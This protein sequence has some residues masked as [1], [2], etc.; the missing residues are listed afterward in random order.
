MPETSV[1]PTWLV[2]AVAVATPLLAFA[3]VIVANVVT[4]MGDTELEVRSRREE[5]MRTLKWAAELAVSDDPAKADLGLRELRALGDSAMLD[6]EQQSFI[7]AALASVYG[8]AEAQIEA[9]EVEG[10]EVVVVVE[11]PVPGEERLSASGPVG[12][13][14]A[15]VSSDV[16]SETH[17]EEQHG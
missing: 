2:I 5:T 14:Q 17:G 4:R 6:P 16:D 12:P 1:V 15:P 10:E 13:G 11:A 7:D 8:A 9:A 3:G